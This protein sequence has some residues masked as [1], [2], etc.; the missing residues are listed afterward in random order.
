MEYLTREIAESLLCWVMPEVLEHWNLEYWTE[1]LTSGRISGS[2]ILEIVSSSIMNTVVS[3]SGED[4][5]L[6]YEKQSL[7]W[8]QERDPQNVRLSY[9]ITKNLNTIS[10]YANSTVFKHWNL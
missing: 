1:S 8:I 6:S 10:T 3:M 7:I 5:D 9:Y 4:R 2:Q